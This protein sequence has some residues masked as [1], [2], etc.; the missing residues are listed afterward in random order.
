MDMPNGTRSIVEMLQ[1]IAL[2]TLDAVNSTNL[3]P[4][5]VSAR[6]NK[7]GAVMD[8]KGRQYPIHPPLHL[9]AVGKAAGAMSAAMIDLLPIPFASGLVISKHHH[10]RGYDFGESITMMEGGHPISDMASVQAGEAA[11]TFLESLEEEFNLIML[12]SGG[13]SALLSTPC[14]GINLKDM[15]TTSKALVRSGADIL[16]INAVRK[17]IE[18]LKGGQL[19]RH[20][21]ARVV[22]LMLSDVVGDHMD[23]IASGLTVPDSTTFWDAGRVVAKYGLQD[24]LPKPVLERIQAGMDGLLAETPK[25]ND[26][27]FERAENIIV[28]S[29]SVAADYAKKAA[30]EKSYPCALVDDQITASVQETAERVFESIQTVRRR[31]HPLAAPCCLI[32]AGEMTVQVNGPGLG[33]RNLHFALEMV[34][35][36]RGIACVAVVSVA[37]DGSDGPT[38]AAGAVVTGDSYREAADA[39]LDPQIYVRDFDSYHFFDVMGSLLRVGPT[40]TNLCDVIIVLIDA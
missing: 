13:G 21:K 9:L 22:A 16:E 24:A 6:K 5:I 18:K 19:L 12:I 27:I 32:L 14:D 17:H 8:V 28:G 11:I 40:G 30:E 39:G 26:P 35:K 7:T 20:T 15:Q 29:P 10:L 4:D 25:E 2:T 36:L 1:S 37:T 23:T 3:L 33:G 34:E 31:S 38:D